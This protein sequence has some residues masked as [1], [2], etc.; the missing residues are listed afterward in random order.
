[1]T[2]SKIIACSTIRD[3]VEALRGDLPVE[4]LEGFLHDTPDVLREKINERIA[5]TPD[6]QTILLAY[7]RCSNGTAELSAGEPGLASLGAQLATVVVDLPIPA[8]SDEYEAAAKKVASAE[9]FHLVFLSSPG[10]G[11]FV[12]LLGASETAPALRL[13]DAALVRSRAMWHATP[14]PELSVLPHGG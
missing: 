14:H 6:A 7:G 10:S 11:A 3:E 1:M 8:R 2:T 13:P 9:R 5:V 4:Y 12:H